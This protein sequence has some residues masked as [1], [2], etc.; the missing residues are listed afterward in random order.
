MR[1]ICVNCWVFCIFT[2]HIL[3]TSV[4]I[5][6]Y[7]AGS[8]IRTTLQALRGFKISP[9]CNTF[10]AKMK[11]TQCKTKQKNVNRIDPTKLRIEFRSFFFDHDSHGDLSMVIYDERHCTPY[12]VF[13]A[14]IWS[15]STVVGFFLPWNWILQGRGYSRG[16]TSVPSLMIFLYFG[17]IVGLMFFNTCVNSNWFESIDIHAKFL[18]WGIMEKKSLWYMSLKLLFKLKTFLQFK[19]FAGVNVH[20]ALSYSIL[21]ICWTL[22]ISLSTFFFK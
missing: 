16:H 20:F 3:S 18:Y 22:S 2:G 6:F 1:E 14:A 7:V 19:V 10:F 12:F 21:R 15:H 13:I 8:I 9:F 5:I 17:Y 11:Y 4:N